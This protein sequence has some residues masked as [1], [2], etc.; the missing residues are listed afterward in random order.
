MPRDSARRVAILPRQPSLRSA[1]RPARPPESALRGDGGEFGGD[2]RLLDRRLRGLLAEPAATVLAHALDDREQIEP[3][4][5]QRVLDARRHLG[6]GVAL[7]EAVLL[8]RAQA[9]GERPRADAG[10]RA[11]ELAE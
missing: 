5:R 3:L 10:E 2:R 4:P 11:L 9:Q 6:V 7:D 1:L 8:E